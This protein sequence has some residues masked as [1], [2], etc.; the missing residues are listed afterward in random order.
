M[1]TPTPLPL[2]VGA[3]SITESWPGSD[4]NR[5]VAADHDARLSVA[6]RARAID[7]GRWRSAHRHAA[8]GGLCGGDEPHGQQEQQA[9]PGHIIASW[10]FL[11]S[12]RASS[13]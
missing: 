11:R 5:P 2:R 9:D 1:T 12:L 8:R 4:R 3:D 10:S 6:A 7:L 13:A